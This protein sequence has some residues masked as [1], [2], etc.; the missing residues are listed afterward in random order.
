MYLETATQTC[1]AGG[2]PRH[3]DAAETGSSKLD[4]FA[5]K[6]RGNA[7]HFLHFWGWIK[8]AQT[9]AEWDQNQ[10]PEA[11]KSTPEAPKS[12]PGALGSFSGGF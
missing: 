7:A 12:T 6:N 8:V 5:S 3:P 10:S 4:Q 2:F 11:P 9:Y 1:Q